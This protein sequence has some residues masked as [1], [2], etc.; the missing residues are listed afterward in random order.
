MKLR[1]PCEHGKYEEH[2]VFADLP[3][4]DFAC[5]GGVFLPESVLVIEKVNGEWVL[6]PPSW[7]TLR[8]VIGLLGELADALIVETSGDP[9][10]FNGL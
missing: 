4:N 6:P 8:S 9:G 5:P 2:K 1:Q 3:S 7:L 10:G